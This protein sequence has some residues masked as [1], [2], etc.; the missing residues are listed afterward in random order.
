VALVYGWVLVGFLLM[1]LCGCRDGW[2]VDCAVVLG[3]NA[4]IVGLSA[5]PVVFLFLGCVMRLA[6]LPTPQNHGMG[7]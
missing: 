7:W 6:L 4:V 1:G 3:W 5:A 2:L